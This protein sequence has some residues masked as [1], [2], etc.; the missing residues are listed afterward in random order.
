[1][2]AENNITSIPP[3]VT[4]CQDLDLAAIKVS[5]GGADS[6]P[7]VCR[8]P[9]PS[10]SQQRGAWAFF[11]CICFFL[12][13]PLSQ[14]EARGR[15]DQPEAARFAQLWDRRGAPLSSPARPAEGQHG[16]QAHGLLFQGR[17]RQRTHRGRAQSPSSR[18]AKLTWELSISKSATGLCAADQA[19]GSPCPHPLRASV[20]GSYASSPSEGVGG[21]VVPAGREG[22]SQLGDAPRGS[23]ERGE[24]FPGAPRPWVEFRAACSR[25]APCFVFAFVVFFFFPRSWFSPH[26]RGRPAAERSRPVEEAGRELGVAE[27]RGSVEGAKRVRGAGRPDS[28]P[29]CF[30]GYNRSSSFQDR[31]GFPRQFQHISWDASSSRSGELALS[32]FLG[33]H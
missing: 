33:V 18:L 11:Y 23:A 14:G 9:S 28:R 21:A 31:G 29:R 8:G 24:S 30:S 20:R 19:V 17:Y 6:P 1:M 22:G 4:L 16:L 7:W 12:F 2:G 15:R 10:R 32:I 5:P 3:L 27:G 26:Q 25:A 13:G